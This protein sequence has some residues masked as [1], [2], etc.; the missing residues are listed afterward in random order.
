M[1]ATHEVYMIDLTHESALSLRDVAK[2]IPP[3]RLGK[4]VSFQC[5]LRWVLDGSLSPSGE[6][7]K[8]E[9]IRLGSRWITSREA[10]QR[11]AER[12]TPPSANSPTS[13]MHTSR[14]RRLAAEQAERELNQ[15]GI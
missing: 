12:L 15:M 7:V 10:L 3:A 1:L 5:V 8:L 14:H 2:L 6:R 13:H 11:F 9:A 4:P